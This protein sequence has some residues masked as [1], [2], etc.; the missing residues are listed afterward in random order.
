MQQLRSGI[1]LFLPVLGLQISGFQDILEPGNNSMEQSFEVMDNEEVDSNSES[2]TN[3]DNGSIY[4]DNGS[5]Y[6]DNEF[7]R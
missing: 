2:D 5:I 3:S 4:S 1:S 6:S 7:D